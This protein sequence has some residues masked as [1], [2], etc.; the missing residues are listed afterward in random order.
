MQA[1]RGA[2]GPCGTN[3]LSR[4]PTVTVGSSALKCVAR[5]CRP[6][7]LLPSDA[8]TVVSVHG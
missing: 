4:P 1:D 6:L 8:V 2:A 3:G 7:Q 5:E